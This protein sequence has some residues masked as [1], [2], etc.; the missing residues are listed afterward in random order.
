MI[1]MGM[2]H[3]NA[4]HRAASNGSEQRVTMHRQGRARINDPDLA[5]AQQ[6]RVRTRAGHGAGVGDDES[7]QSWR[8]QPGSAGGE[9]S[10]LR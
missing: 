2:C 3:D 9:L 10:G 4:A 5:L 1:A 7:L 6:V 8:Q